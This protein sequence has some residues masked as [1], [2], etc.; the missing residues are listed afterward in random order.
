MW[1]QAVRIVGVSNDQHHPQGSRLENWP[2]VKA[3]LR[4][5]HSTTTSVW[6]AS[7]TRGGILVEV[8]IVRWKSPGLDAKNVIGKTLRR[9]TLVELRSGGSR[10]R[11]R[12][13]DATSIRLAKSSARRPMSLFA[14]CVTK[15]SDRLMTRGANMNEGVCG[16]VF[17]PV[18][19]DISAEAS[20]KRSRQVLQK[21]STFC[22][23][24]A[25][26]RVRRVTYRPQER[27]VR[28]IGRR[29]TASYRSLPK[30]EIEAMKQGRVPIVRSPGRFMIRSPT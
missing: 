29:E 14:H 22:V 3:H 11:M 16:R 2:S 27:S 28:K 4:R 18:G 7:S 10:Q 25:N 6:S 21:R 19:V 17:D 20:Q 30:S 12:E 5:G 26:G 8:E 15:A 24:P 9:R 23:W 1:T 13:R